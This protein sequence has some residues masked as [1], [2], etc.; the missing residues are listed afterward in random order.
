MNQSNPSLNSVFMQTLLHMQY[1]TLRRVSNP[2][3]KQTSGE[4]AALDAKF[5]AACEAL[6]RALNPPAENTPMPSSGYVVP[7]PSETVERLR[8]LEE[9]ADVLDEDE[10]EEWDP[11]EDTGPAE[12]NFEGPRL[13]EE[14]PDPKEFKDS[15]GD[16]WNSQ[17]NPPPDTINPEVMAYKKKISHNEP[18]WN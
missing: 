16:G 1:E 2:D 12:T 3:F 18:F 5:K 17:P 8:E 9:E 7:L 10:D 14:A 4:W 15:K 13:V 6:M 11:D